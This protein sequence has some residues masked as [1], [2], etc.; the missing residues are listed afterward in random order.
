V[1]AKT[2]ERVSAGGM[3]Q[4]TALVGSMIDPANK[5]LLL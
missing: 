5:M 1:L 4:A 2:R 3:L